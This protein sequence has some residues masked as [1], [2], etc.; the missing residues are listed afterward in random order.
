MDADKDADVAW[1]WLAIVSLTLF[2][3]LGSFCIAGC[4]PLH[5]GPISP[6]GENRRALDARIPG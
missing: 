3:V 5:K 4:R 2:L 6:L 1:E